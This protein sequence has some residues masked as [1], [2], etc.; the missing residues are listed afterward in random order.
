[1]R[2]W[3]LVLALLGPIESCDQV[4]RTRVQ[5]SRSAALEPVARFLSDIGKPQVVFGVLLLACVVQPQLG[6]PAAR[7]G[8]MALVPVNVVTETLKRATF[9]TRPDGERKRSN[10]SFPSSHAANAFAM[11]AVLSRFWRRLSPA[12][13][14]GAAGIA[15]SRVYLDRHYASDVVIGMLVGV[16]AVWLTTWAFERRGFATGPA[17]SAIVAQDRVDPRTQ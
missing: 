12:L 4:V 16:G 15:A 5:S 2:T 14:I 3:L 8:L 17:G 11:A 13:W 9:R 1:V 6:V 7:L 10:A